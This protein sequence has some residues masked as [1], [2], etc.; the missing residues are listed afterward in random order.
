MCVLH[1]CPVGTTNCTQDTIFW[2]MVLG[3]REEFG[4]SPLSSLFYLLSREQQSHWQQLFIVARQ[5]SFSSMW[6][7]IFSSRRFFPLS[8]WSAANFSGA[9][10]CCVWRKSLFQHSSLSAH[11]DVKHTWQCLPADRPVCCWFVVTWTSW[12]SFLS[13]AVDS[14]GFLPDCGSD[15]T[16]PCTSYLHVDVCTVDLGSCNCFEMAPSD[17]AEIR[18]E[19]IRLSHCSICVWV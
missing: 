15:T 7:L 18:A 6:P 3:F 16:V 11:V 19:L 14:L 1:H 9:L 17:F 2:L 4:D 10:R 13:A 12:P 5:P 8:M